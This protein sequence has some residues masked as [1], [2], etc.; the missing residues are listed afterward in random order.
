LTD[1]VQV[2]FEYN[3]SIICLDKSLPLPS[4]VASESIILASRSVVDAYTLS[5]I[6]F[7]IKV[8]KP[9]KASTNIKIDPIYRIV[10]GGIKNSW[11]T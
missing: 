8:N 2:R 4:I 5:N 7:N 9:I 11:I 6:T 3:N 10:Y 1:P